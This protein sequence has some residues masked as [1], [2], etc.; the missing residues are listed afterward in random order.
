[1]NRCPTC[2]GAKE[3][4]NQIDLHHPGKHIKACG[5]FRVC[6]DLFHKEPRTVPEIR[7]WV[8]RGEG[9]RLREELGL[10]QADIAEE[11]GYS[12]SVVSE[13]ET[14]RKVP[15]FTGAIA[16]HRALMKLSRARA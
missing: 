3:S 12:V 7:E 5:Q 9:L 16:Y 10:R 6:D 2:A 14:K 8:A 13:Y 4:P 1:M 15:S 11:M